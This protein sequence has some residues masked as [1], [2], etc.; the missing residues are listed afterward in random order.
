MRYADAAPDGPYRMRLDAD[1]RASLRRGAE[2]R[3][4]LSGRWWAG[5]G[6]LCRAWDKF[7]PKFDCWP[8]SIDGAVINLYGDHD[9]MYLQGVL[10]SE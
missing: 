7:M 3:L 1:G 2:Q 9:T 10:T 8:V 6:R 4:V 5:D